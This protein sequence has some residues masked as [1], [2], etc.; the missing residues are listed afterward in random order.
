MSDVSGPAGITPA[1]GA[2]P[3]APA[4]ERVGWGFTSLY[5]AAYMGS[6]LLLLAPLLV[7]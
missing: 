5:A 1:A 2:A 6:I 4:V 7:S 3:N